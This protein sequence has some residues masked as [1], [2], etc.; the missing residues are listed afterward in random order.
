[1]LLSLIVAVILSV[2]AV[3]FANDNQALIQLQLFGL[4]LQGK[5]GIVVVAAFALGA[6]IG[7]AVFLPA[8]LAQGWSLIRSRRKV[9]DLERVGRSGIDG[10]A[11]QA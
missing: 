5:T 8:Y 7:I 2:V 4:R 6:V 9:E 10:N 1:M 3:F 11:K